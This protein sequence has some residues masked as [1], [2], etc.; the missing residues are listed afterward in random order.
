MDTI[1]DNWHDAVGAAKATVIIGLI[2]LVIGLSMTSETTFNGVTS[3]SNFDI[4]RLFLGGLGMYTAFGAFNDGR[5]SRKPALN[6]A[7]AAAGALLAVLALLR[8]FD[9]IM[10]P[11]G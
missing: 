3:C 2:A 10:S 5:S 8:A 4:G 1:T 9:I 6:Y 11:C 7:L